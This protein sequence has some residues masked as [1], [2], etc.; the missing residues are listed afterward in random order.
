VIAEGT[1]AKLREQNDVRC[2]AWI[3]GAM[4]RAIEMMHGFALDVKLVSYGT[5]SR[6]I[7]QMARDFA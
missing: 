7:M 3:Q 2:D 6:A 4:R 5:P 1:P